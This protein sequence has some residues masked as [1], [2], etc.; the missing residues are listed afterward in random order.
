MKMKIK[1]NINNKNNALVTKI[2]SYINI[3]DMFVE[4]NVKKK[5]PRIITTDVFTTS[6]IFV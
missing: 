2:D 4:K 1:L 6:I 3:F 5:K